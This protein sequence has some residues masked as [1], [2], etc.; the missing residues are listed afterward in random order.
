[1]IKL[2][3]NY[4]NKNKTMLKNHITGLEA[5]AHMKMSRAKIAMNEN[6]LEFVITN[7]LISGSHNYSLKKIGG[8]EVIMLRINGRTN[9][10]VKSFVILCHI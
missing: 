1:M 10:R 2:I 3:L 4:G 5:Y 8:K 6:F 7:V 9:Q